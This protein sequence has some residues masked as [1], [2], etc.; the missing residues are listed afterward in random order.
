MACGMSE[1][2][3]RVLAETKTERALQ[4]GVGKERMQGHR[5][6]RLEHPPKLST[7][8]RA[9]IVQL[10]C[11]E[12]IVKRLL[13]L[14]RSSQHILLCEANADRILHPHFS[15]AHCPIDLGRKSFSVSCF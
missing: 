10:A 1:Y 5:R 9:Q 11:P 7:P 3:I 14:P 13:C 12:L 6:G 4:L 2:V 8:A 15:Y